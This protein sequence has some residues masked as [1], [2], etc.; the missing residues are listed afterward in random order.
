MSTALSRQASAPTAVAIRNEVDLRNFIVDRAGDFVALAKAAGTTPEAIAAEL[1]SAA[2]KNPQVL[3]CEPDSIMNFLYDAAK[4]GL[5]IGH[6]LFPVPVKKKGVLQLEGWIG[7]K[8]MRELV[9]YGRG[10]R[11]IYAQVVYDG[12]PFE[13]ILGMYP[14]IKHAKGPHHGDMRFAISVY[15]VA[16]IS[17]TVRRH[18]LLTKE[19]VDALRKLNRGDTTRSDSPWVTN[20]KAMWKAKALLTLAKD[21]PRNP[22]LAA[23]LAIAGRIDEPTDD[24]ALPA[25]PSPAPSVPSA[26]VEEA[27]FEEVETK[28]EPVRLPQWRGHPLAGKALR[29]VDTTDLEALYSQLATAEE[30]GDKRYSDLN[31]QIA[32][33]LDERRA[34]A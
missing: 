31:G 33:E 12:D 4:T 7:Y 34:A 27:T 8:G 11:D 23:A 24:E 32:S 26:G 29:E 16:V 5:I 13:E 18:V 20:P 25:N 14:D 9:I 1:V 30:K 17:Q 21:L 22:R 6:G 10:A 19:E 2:R 3:Q 15:A 28:A